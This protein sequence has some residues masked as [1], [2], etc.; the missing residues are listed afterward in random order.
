MQATSGVEFG[1]P[2]GYDANTS[3]DSCLW[4]SPNIGAN[5]VKLSDNIQKGVML[6]PVVGSTAPKTTSSGTNDLRAVSEVMNIFPN[7]TS[8]NIFI[9]LKEGE[10]SHYKALI[11]NNI[12]QSLGELPFQNEIN[13]N[14]YQNGIYYLQITNLKTNE[15]FNQKII[16]MKP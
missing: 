15:R 7:P 10:F 6:R 1:I 11:F 9:Q 12:G 14:Q 2:L 3:C 13:L 16:I 8:G 5:W 4:V